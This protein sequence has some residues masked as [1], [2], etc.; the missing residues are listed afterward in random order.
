MCTRN[1]AHSIA[2]AVS[3]VMGNS[4]PDYTLT[5]I[6][7]STTNDTELAVAPIAAADP[8]VRYVHT[9]LAGLSRAYNSGI[10]AT[11]G[12]ILWLDLPLEFRVSPEPLMLIRPAP[13]APERNAA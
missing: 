7:Q 11:D 13:P 4:Y 12:E 9:D 1:R 5:I 10:R 6:D 8:R 3:S 2:Q